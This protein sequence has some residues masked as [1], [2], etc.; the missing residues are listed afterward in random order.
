[1]L[2]HTAELEEDDGR[3]SYG[4]DLG[5]VAVSLAA[6]F[7]VARWLVIG[8]TPDDL[9]L[10]RAAVAGDHGDP[11]SAILL[12]ADGLEQRVRVL[13]PREPVLL[14][15]SSLRSWPR[16]FEVLA[17]LKTHH[18]PMVLLFSDPDV[19]L[20]RV[21]AAARARSGRAVAVDVGTDVRAALVLRHVRTAMAGP[22]AGPRRAADGRAT[23]AERSGTALQPPALRHPLTGTQV[24][25]AVEGYEHV[26]RDPDDP[27]PLV[28]LDGHGR[29]RQEVADEVIGLAA[30]GIVPIVNGPAV[31]SLP[32]PGTLAR[33]LEPVTRADIWSAE[34]A[35]RQ[36]V[37]LRRATLRDPLRGMGADRT[38]VSVLLVSRRPEFIGRAVRHVRSQSHADLELVLIGHGWDPEPWARR[39][40][41]VSGPTLLTSRLSPQRTLGDGLNLA[42]EMA[43]GE[44]VVKLDDDDWYGEDL[45]ADLLLALRVSGAE[46]LGSAMDFIYLSSLDVTVR[47]GAPAERYG[48]HLSGATMLIR[49]DDL[50]S[51]GGW[52]RVPR[53][54]DSRLLDV[55]RQAGAAHYAMHGFGYVVN[56]HGSGNTFHAEDAW[57][58]SGCVAQW[59]GLDLGAADVA[60]D[61]QQ[62]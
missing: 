52:P 16:W 6:L 14:V 15:V 34:G 4:Q 32:L 18:G 9:E 23:N 38:T 11:S 44:L 57:F 54:V 7:E 36:S 28:R 58:L 33:L 56:R 35:V 49:R 29:D 51:L 45:V 46:L 47:R 50:R 13:S 1:M 24:E 39:Q 5:D 8:E 12:A 30:R 26:L 62:P 3:T 42:L 19:A 59:P 10:G 21:R 41:D 60:T 48:A 25:R 37:R 17:T 22:V 53:A 2:E 27:P 40:D 61:R 55:V 20:E 43:S 31:G